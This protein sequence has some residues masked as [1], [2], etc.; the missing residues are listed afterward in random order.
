MRYYAPLGALLSMH[1]TLMRSL[2]SA[3]QTLAGLAFGIAL[4]GAVLILSEPS[5]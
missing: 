5:V 2:R 4:A 1:P 3:L